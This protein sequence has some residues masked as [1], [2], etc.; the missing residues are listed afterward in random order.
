MEEHEDEIDPLHH[1]KQKHGIGG[2]GGY[3]VD[4]TSTH[5]NAL[6]VWIRSLFNNFLD[7]LSF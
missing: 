4:D 1:T 5:L 7:L 2:G 6:S 3:E